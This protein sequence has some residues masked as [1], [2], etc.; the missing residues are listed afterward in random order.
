MATALSLCF[1]MGRQSFVRGDSQLQTDAQDSPMIQQFSDFVAAEIGRLKPGIRRQLL[2]YSL[3]YR[4]KQRLANNETLLDEEQEA[5]T[6]SYASQLA[7]DY[8]D[9]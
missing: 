7:R 9:A 8:F 6:I 5:E 2:Y 4:L 3:F 1:V